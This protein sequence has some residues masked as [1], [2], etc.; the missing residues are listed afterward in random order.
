MGV[1][2]MLHSL[3]R[4]LK[5]IVPGRARHALVKFYLL[6]RSEGY[7]GGV[8]SAQMRELI[9]VWDLIIKQQGWLR[10]Q[11]AKECLNAQG[12]PI[13]WYSYPAIEYLS[14]I[15]WSE[16]SV[17]EYGSGNSSLWWAG[18]A[19]RVTS[20]EFNKEWFEHVSARLPE[21]AEILH[22]SDPQEYVNALEPGHEL[23][24]IDGLTHDY[25]RLRCAEAA[26]KV[27]PTNGL[28]ILDNS[29]SLPRSTELLRSHGLLEIDFAGIY[30]LNTE[31]AIT[32]LFCGPEW[33]PRFTL[34]NHPSP[35]IGGRIQNWEDEKH[36]Y[37]QT[38]RVR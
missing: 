5:R 21:N 16:T 2:I 22:R 28:I 34:P 29:D 9:D 30:P 12:E 32:S 4:A 14:K 24:V 26:I 33:K 1:N 15:D 36:E 27:L 17:F 25:G 20:V 23:I 13:P 3:N 31:A 6:N 10:A 7:A 37:N 8:S 35:A 19:K 18:R 38:S 11:Q